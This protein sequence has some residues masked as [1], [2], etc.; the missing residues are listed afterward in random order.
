MKSID[1]LLRE[2]LYG[3]E[4]LEKTAAAHAYAAELS[5][6][7]LGELESFMEK[8]GMVVPGAEHEATFQ[9]KLAWA[10][11]NGRELAREHAGMRKIAYWGLGNAHL[12]PEAAQK[13]LDKTSSARAE[14]MSAY[15]EKVAMRPGPGKQLDEEGA[16]KFEKKFRAQRAHVKDGIAPWAYGTGAPVPTDEQRIL[17]MSTRPPGGPAKVTEGAT[18]AA[19]KGGR[20]VLKTILKHKAPIGAGLGAAGM[21]AGGAYLASRMD[22]ESSLRAEVMS[23][24]LEKAAG[25]GFEA[26]RAI[27]AEAG[28]EMA[29]VAIAGALGV[30]KHM[31]SRS[32]TLEAMKSMKASGAMKSMKAAGARA[33]QNSRMAPTRR[34]VAAAPGNVGPRGILM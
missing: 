33:I 8:I 7:E 16:A 28:Q 27:A 1:E 18:K 29:K 26:R 4:S 31:A 21:L 17:R 19:E 12:T 23:A 2:E 22:K 15:L 30:A 6:M 20:G 24:Y 11:A 25:L 14:I 3:G 13:Y 5:G 9:E 32:A 34:L 10:D